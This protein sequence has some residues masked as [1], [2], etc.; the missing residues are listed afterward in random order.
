M[1]CL[2]INTVS[3]TVY[4]P[5][6]EFITEQSLW[7]S[8]SKSLQLF[9]NYTCICTIIWFVHFFLSWDLSPSKAETLL[10]FAHHWRTTLHTVPDIEKV[11]NIIGWMKKQYV[12]G[13]MEYTHKI[14]IMGF[15]RE[16]VGQEKVCRRYCLG[17]AMDSHRWQCHSSICVFILGV[18]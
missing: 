5:V 9:V 14:I 11:F 3:I 12:K 17:R 10:L 8:P 13:Y 2:S 18:G 6:D 1:Y 16:W 4:H 15:K 7:D